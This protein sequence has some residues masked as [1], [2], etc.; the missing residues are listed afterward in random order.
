MPATGDISVKNAVGEFSLKNAGD[1]EVKNAT[2]SLKITAAGQVE[3]KGAAD[4][5][6]DLFFQAC[7]ALSTQ[8]APGFG[9]PTSTVATFAQLMAKAQALKA[10]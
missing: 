5:L 2:G 4:G 10:T 1:I 8:T 3:L 6:V 9:A 7:Q